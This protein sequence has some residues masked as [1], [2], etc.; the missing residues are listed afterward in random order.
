MFNSCSAA[1]SA[2]SQETV[3]KLAGPNFPCPMYVTV[4]E[5]AVAKLNHTDC[6]AVLAGRDS[7]H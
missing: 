7:S 1:F 3:S 2:Y 6:L 4:L 5:V